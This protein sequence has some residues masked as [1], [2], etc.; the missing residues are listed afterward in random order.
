[1]APGRVKP[2][3]VGDL[4]RFGGFYLLWGSG[5]LGRFLEWAPRF[6]DGLGEGLFL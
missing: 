5:A 4:L 3:Q 1:M 2:Q 6:W